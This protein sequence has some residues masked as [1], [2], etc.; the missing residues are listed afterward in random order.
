MYYSHV[1]VEEFRVIQNHHHHHLF[2]NVNIFHAQLGLV[3]PPEMK[4]STYP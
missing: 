1:T 3:V 4:P 2:L